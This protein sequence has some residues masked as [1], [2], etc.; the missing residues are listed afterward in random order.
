MVYPPPF[1]WR[2]Y[3]LR[4]G[5]LYLKF[6][7]HI[8][9]PVFNVFAVNMFTKSTDDTVSPINKY[10]PAIFFI[11]I[12]SGQTIEKSMKYFSFFRYL[13]F[14]NRHSQHCYCLFRIWIEKS[15]LSGKLATLAQI[16]LMSGQEREQSKT[17]FLQEHLM[18]LQSDLLVHWTI[19]RNFWGDDWRSVMMIININSTGNLILFQNFWR[20]RQYTHRLLEQDFFSCM[21]SFH[22]V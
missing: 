21:Q 16:L 19:S 3:T 1:N 8:N 18:V 10:S 7:L 5:Y 20:V 4:P 9:I 2:G 14:Y 13:V 11:Y 6:R 15:V 17:C 22:S 12:Q